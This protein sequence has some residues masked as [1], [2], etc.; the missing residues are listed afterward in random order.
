MPTQGN[1]KLRPA[2]GLMS[3]N[4]NHLVELRGIWRTLSQGDVCL[5]RG[6]R[7]HSETMPLA[8]SEDFRVK[9]HNWALPSLIIL[10]QIEI[11]DYFSIIFNYL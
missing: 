1:A 11:K 2:I 8:R 7:S 4:I 3:M 10:T 6:A 9:V 5:R